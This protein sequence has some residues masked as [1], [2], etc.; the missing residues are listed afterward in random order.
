MTVGNITQQARCRV[1]VVTD[2]S[3]LWWS[4]TGLSSSF[5]LHPTLNV[6]YAPEPPCAHEWG[7][8]GD[9]VENVSVYRQQLWDLQYKA[10]VFSI[11][12]DIV[13]GI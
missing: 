1:R 7:S 11:K 10:P 8:F 12:V 4:V 6:Q 3:W 13:T 2:V 9:S 5:I